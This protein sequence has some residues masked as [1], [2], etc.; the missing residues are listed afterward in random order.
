M[1]SSSQH[2]GQM[3]LAG[4]SWAVLSTACG[5]SS[6]GNGSG[7]GTTTETSANQGGGGSS[8]HSGHATGGSSPADTNRASG[9]SADTGGDSHTTNAPA[10]GGKS[11][12]AGTPTAGGSGSASSGSGGTGRG[13]AGTTSTSSATGGFDGKG[14]RSGSGGGA[15]TGGA[16]AGGTAGPGSHLGGGSGLGGGSSGSGGASVIGTGSVTTT[17]PGAVPTGVTAA[18]CSCEQWGQWTH[19]DATFYNDI[20]GS[21]PG[22]QCIWAT[23]TNQFGMAAKHP[24][25]SGIKSYPNIS[26]SPGKAISAINTYT[27]SFN[28][29]VPNGGA[30][31][32]AYDIWVKNSVRIEIMLWLNRT[33]GVAPIATKYDGSGAVPD[34]TNVSVGGHTWNVYYG[35]NGSNDVVSL[36]RSANTTSGTVDIKAILDWIIKNKGSFTS[37]W[38]L[39]QV[40]LGP[41]I[42]SDGGDVQSFVVNAFSVSST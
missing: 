22:P 28:F 29:T 33:G 6:P 1:M 11:G 39:D 8:S 40:Q 37:S 31:E 35:S 20:W 23:E 25:T 3:I 19:G 12:G 42:S 15:A 21:G 24:A 32:V 17:C 38:T 36:L 4:L 27:S 2:L 14:G 13:G 9:G 26:Y 30:W 7:R 10:A 18:W 16:A 41:E 34:V 5:D